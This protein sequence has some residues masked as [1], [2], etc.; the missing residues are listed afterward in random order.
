MRGTH[1]GG[2]KGAR[3]A[4]APAGEVGLTP[5]YDNDRGVSGTQGGYHRQDQQQQQYS[6]EY[7][8]PE[9]DSQPVVPPSY[10]AK[11]RPDGDAAGNASW[12]DGAHKG[13]VNFAQGDQ[14]AELGGEEGGHGAKSSTFGGGYGANGGGVSEL[15]AGTPPANS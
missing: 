11:V 13:P 2:D 9:L 5:M 10:Q 1:D 3:Y 12:S 6:G 4:P 7:Q 14:R 8:K 15:P